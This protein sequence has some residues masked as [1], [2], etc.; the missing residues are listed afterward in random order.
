MTYSASSLA[1]AAREADRP[2]AQREYDSAAAILWAM[3]QE[4]ADLPISAR[5]SRASRPIDSG[6]PDSAIRQ[7]AKDRAQLL[8]NELSHRAASDAAG[9]AQWLNGRVQSLGA[10]PFTWPGSEAGEPPP[11]GALAPLCERA[12]CPLWWRR[13]LRRAVV[14]ARE[15]EAMQAG[16]VCARRRQIYCT[17]D[18]LKRRAERTKSNADML[19][20]TKIESQDG[21]TITL[22]EA[23]AAGMANKT[24]RRGELMTRINGCDLWAQAAGLVG[25]FTTNTT[26]SRFH[27]QTMHDGKNP[28]HD[29]STPKDGQAWLRNTWARCRAKLARQGVRCFG[30]RV[31][32]P[33]HDGTPHWHMLLWCEPGQAQALQDT[34]RGAWLADEGD[35]PGAAAHRF[36]AKEL[37][38]GGA[39]A[40][41][42]KYVAKNIDDAGQVGVDG[43]IEQASADAPAVNLGTGKAARVEAWAAAWSI[44][45]FQAVGQPPVTVWREL[46][47]IDADAVQGACLAVQQAHAAVNRTGARRANWRDYMAAQGGPMVGRGYPVRILTDDEPPDEPGRYGDARQ[48]RT[49]GVMH[50]DRPGEWILS[51]RRQWREAGTWRRPKGWTPGA[52]AER[53]PDFD[54]ALAAPAAPRTRVNNCTDA[55]H[56]DRRARLLILARGGQ[57][58]RNQHERTNH[59]R[60]GAP[61][62]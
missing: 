54:G 22:A 1:W 18:T 26:P 25:I 39:A 36:K 13:Q 48:A 50:V 32:E 11:P 59:R 42:A 24:N 3:Q 53:I 14:R 28:K 40:Y 23:A 44:R 35:E 56:T 33:H 41:C 52:P 20:R 57:T 21:E 55:A 6:M 27:P 10:R 2:H 15:T 47:R 62:G 8:E 17:D 12:Q 58:E 16:E 34:M 49:L 4:H 7:A 46:R 43:H 9:L 60:P 29:G 19:A 31:A 51:G 5:H 30:F 45:Q 38:A 61:P 37:D